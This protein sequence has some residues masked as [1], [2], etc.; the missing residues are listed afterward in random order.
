MEGSTGETWKK[1]DLEL[2]TKDKILQ[3][4]LIPLERLAMMHQAKRVKLAR[5]YKLA[6]C[7]ESI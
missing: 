3:P 1:P 7:H 5:L 6:S 4:R 2:A